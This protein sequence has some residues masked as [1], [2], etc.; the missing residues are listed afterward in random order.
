MLTI[1]PLLFVSCKGQLRSS[2][3]PTVFIDTTT[4]FTKEIPV[5]KNGAV[6]VFYQSAKSKQ[7]Q[8]GLDSLENGFDNLQIR[9]WYDYALVRERKLV[10]LTNK[11]RKWTAK[12]C[13]LQVAWD[14]KTE[15]ILTKKIIKVKPGSGWETFSKKLLNLKIV[16]LPDQNEVKGYGQGFDGKTYHVE[17]ATKN[18]Y[19]FYGYWEPQQFQG[20]FWQAKN[21]ADILQ[22]LET[23]LGV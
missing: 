6:N 5:Q 8:L 21:M 10:V 17:V 13:Y 4:S 22:L 2:N 7:R 20:R 14:G 1:A 11:E 23:E 15:S 18:L 19:R 12:V 3:S 16:T 9:V